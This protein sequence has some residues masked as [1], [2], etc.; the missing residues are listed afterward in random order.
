MVVAVEISTI[1]SSL[2]VTSK[3]E[4]I[5]EL[6]VRVAIVEGHLFD[7]AYVDRYDSFCQGN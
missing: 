1:G 3:R 5:V 4:G 2:V 7:F 6:T